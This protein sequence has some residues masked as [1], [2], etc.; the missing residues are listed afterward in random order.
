MK[1]LVI[2]ALLM[3]GINSGSIA[4]EDNTSGVL[5]DS[6]RLH[7]DNGDF[8]KAADVYLSFTD[9]GAVSTGLFYNLGNCYFKL[10]DKARAV[11][12]FEKA[13][14]LD[15]SNENAAHNLSIVNGTLVDKFE[16]TPTFSVRPFFKAI[17]NVISYDLLGLLSIVCLFGAAITFYFIKKKGV[18]VRFINSW[19]ILVVAGL[20]YLWGAVQK[21]EVT[22]V[23]AGIVSMNGL[24]VRSEPNENSTLLFD[25]NEG[26]KIEIIQ[27]N[28]DWLNVK[29][30]DGNQG[31]VQSV[32]I[33]K[34]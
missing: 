10:G 2:I 17:N 30:Q 16:V 1:K 31:W 12:Y 9:S 22:S 29:T 27:I 8:V 13:L 14:D 5:L 26:T 28:S 20:L 19:L 21:T 3:L 11:L 4:R 32:L 24:R 15:G 7:Y 33:F 6:A 25:L 18:K 23:T 34:I